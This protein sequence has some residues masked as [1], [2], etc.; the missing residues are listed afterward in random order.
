MVPSIFFYVKKARWRNVYVLF[1]KEDYEFIYSYIKFII[2]KK[3]DKPKNFKE[4]VTNGE[5]GQETR[6]Q[7]ERKGIEVRFL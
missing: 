2:L 1:K 7:D 3:K 6:K 5:G 4:E